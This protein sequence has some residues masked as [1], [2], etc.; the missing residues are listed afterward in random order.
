MN[1]EGRTWC[2]FYCKNFTKQFDMVVLDEAMS[3]FPEPAS[4]AGPK[5]PKALRPKVQTDREL[6]QGLQQLAAALLG[7]GRSSGSWV[8]GGGFGWGRLTSGQ[9]LEHLFP[10]AGQTGTG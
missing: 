8:A 6:Q 2:G 4:P 5:R 3:S 9:Y 7:P 1:R 10:V